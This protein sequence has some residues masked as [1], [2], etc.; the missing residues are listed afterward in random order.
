MS[1]EVR[2]PVRLN[3]HAIDIMPDVPDVYAAV[4]KV[5]AF[6]WRWHLTA[7]LGGRTIYGPFFAWTER[8]AWARAHAAAW[9]ADS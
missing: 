1:A 8:G 4:R 6:R 7:G 3:A 5:R 2:R 9:R